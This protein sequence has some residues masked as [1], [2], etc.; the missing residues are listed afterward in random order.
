MILPDQRAKRA[1]QGHNGGS[2][3][4]SSIKTDQ[5]RQKGRKKKGKERRGSQTARKHDFHHFQFGLLNR[6][7]PLTAS[8]SRF[9]PVF[10]PFKHQP[11]IESIKDFTDVACPYKTQPPQW[12]PQ[13]PCII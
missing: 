3:R 13:T 11:S 5:I 1:R 12:I 4:Y 2:E 9:E 10:G 7:R 6:T 8:E